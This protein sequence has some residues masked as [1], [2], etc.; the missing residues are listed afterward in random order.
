MW[1]RMKKI[2]CLSW[3]LLICVIPA[4]PAAAKNHSE[5]TESPT[6]GYL[7]FRTKYATVAWREGALAAIERVLTHHH[8]RTHRPYPCWNA[9]TPY[10]R[11]NLPVSLQLD[12]PD[13]ARTATFLAA[14][15][16]PRDKFD[17]NGRDGHFSIT[18]PPSRAG[19]TTWR[20][21]RTTTQVPAA[22]TTHPLIGLV[23]ISG[24]MNKKKK[25]ATLR[26]LMQSA[27]HFSAL[28]TFAEPNSLRSATL[29]SIANAAPHGFTALYDNLQL[30][31]AQN[32]SAEIIVITDGKD[33]KS[34]LN[35]QTLATSVAQSAAKIHIVLTGQ[36][37]DA[38]FAAIAERTGGLVLH[39]LNET[40]VIT[41]E[42][43]QAFVDER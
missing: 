33:N 6:L 19:F 23:D 18:P 27:L 17:A 28:Y 5:I 37:T 39:D 34:T 3:L 32:P 8:V 30:L 42:S 43:V 24:S 12:Q 15:H 11:F 26:G 7:Q 35:L 16:L 36:S 41:Q 9:L 40:G 13:D 22:L 21:A 10:R 31:R 4:F 1:R 2:I 20:I 29:A 14:A 25:L 38:H